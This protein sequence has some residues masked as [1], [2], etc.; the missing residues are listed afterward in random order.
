MLAHAI[1][2]HGLDKLDIVP[3][4]FIAGGSQQ[5][6]GPVALVK[7]ELEHVWPPVEHETVTQ[8]VH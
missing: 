5:G 4:R 6:I 3:E 7:H 1:E 8:G 2:P